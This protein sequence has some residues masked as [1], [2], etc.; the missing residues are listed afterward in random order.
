MVFSLEAF[1]Y[2]TLPLFLLLFQRGLTQSTKGR[3]DWKVITGLA[4]LSVFAAPVL[5]IPAYSIPV[6]IGLAIFYVIWLLNP[7][8]LQKWK[9]SAQFVTL[10]V[11][12]LFAVNIWWIYPTIFLYSTQLMRAGGASYGATG[13]A[14]LSTPTA[15][16][17]GQARAVKQ[18]PAISSGRSEGFCPTP[19]PT[20]PSR[21]SVSCRA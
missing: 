12:A 2:A 14:D 21:A 8:H 15:N 4:G 6:L 17:I 18:S 16:G 7:E 10:A 1:L 11:L 20:C 19:S 5:G 3:I 13:L 9:G